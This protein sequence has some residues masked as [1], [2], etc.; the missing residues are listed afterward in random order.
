M[1]SVTTFC[2]RIINHPNT[3]LLIPCLGGRNLLMR[4]RGHKRSTVKIPAHRE[5]ILTRLSEC[6]L[7]TTDRETQR[8]NDKRSIAS[9]TAKRTEKTACKDNEEGIA[10]ISKFNRRLRTHR[11][12]QGPALMAFAWYL[13]WAVRRQPRVSLRSRLKGLWP[14]MH[15]VRSM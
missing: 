10:A 3:D 6:F 15:R 11:K 14:C 1:I 5:S 9:T 13:G 8:L 2:R 7:L 4:S 12:T